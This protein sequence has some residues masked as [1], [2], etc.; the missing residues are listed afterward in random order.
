MQTPRCSI[1]RF[2][3]STLYPHYGHYGVLWCNMQN[4]PRCYTLGEVGGGGCCAPREPTR[5][6]HFILDRCPPFRPRPLLTTWYMQLLHRRSTAS[7]K[8]I[9]E[10]HFIPTLHFVPRSLPE[11]GK[12]ACVV[13]F[14]FFFLIFL[15][16]PFPLPYSPFTYNSSVCGTSLFTLHSTPR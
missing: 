11:G 2:I 12:Q 4:R 8:W 6:T 7:V 9:H 13:L 3:S 10:P 16:F 1:S 15:F 14:F 5:G